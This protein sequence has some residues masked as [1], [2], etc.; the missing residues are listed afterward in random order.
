[1]GKLGW[2]LGGAA[3]G[4]AV[5]ALL[6]KS[7]APSAPQFVPQLPDLGLPPAPSQEAAPG[8]DFVWPPCP[9]PLQFRHPSG[10]CIPWCKGNQVFDKAGN[11]IPNPCPPCNMYM[12]DYNACVR[13]PFC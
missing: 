4:Y 11:C 1:M 13:G 2:F 8:R 9:D 7:S 10:K 5:Y 6:N 3:A 12:P